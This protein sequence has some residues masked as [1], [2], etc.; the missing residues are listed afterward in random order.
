MKKV[1]TCSKSPSHTLFYRKMVVEG[2]AVE[3]R[4]ENDQPL[5]VQ[6]PQELTL[7]KRLTGVFCLVCESQANVRLPF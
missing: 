6:D 5:D 2:V 7:V 1:L 4:D 3:T